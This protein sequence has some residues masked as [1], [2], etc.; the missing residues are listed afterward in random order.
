MTGKKNKTLKILSEFRI[1]IIMVL[2]II[3]LGM[4]EPSFLRLSNF[5]NI[6]KQIA[7]NAILAAG[8]SFVILTGG[9]DISV[10]SAL[11]LVG[12]VSVNLIA[13][14]MNIV[15]VLMLS[16]AMGAL[17]GLFN[18][19]FIAYFRLQP[20]IVT[21]ATMSICRGLT[22]IYTKGAPITLKTSLASG[23]IY[24]WIGSGTLFGGIPFSLVLVVVLYAMAYYVLNKTAYGRQVY[25]VG[26]NEEAARLSGINSTRAKMMAYVICGMT[27]ALAG[28]IISA[29][30]SSAQ[31][32]AGEGYEMDA[33]AAVVIGGTSLRGGEGRV[34]YTI[35][36][37]LI[38]GMLNNIMNLVGVESYYQTVVKGVVI[39]VAVL[40]DA[41]TSKSLVK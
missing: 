40:L 14:G 37:A 16:I 31:P 25:A 38:I 24:K 4:I 26:G 10:G 22:N 17:I 6:F 32:N 11:A 29:R 35:M 13:G 28:I 27:A 39:L 36:G 8:M 23:K 5:S 33:I 19:I 20:M 2:V 3:V 41:R 21:L 12:A 34:L 1:F 18:G 15:M 9:I 30:V 7:T